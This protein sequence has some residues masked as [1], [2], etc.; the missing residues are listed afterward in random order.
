M[1]QFNTEKKCSLAFSIIKK[2]RKEEGRKGGG[3]EGRKERG[4]D[5]GSH[6]NI[7]D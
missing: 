7:G 4:K 5:I 2:E 3:R 1:K 6:R